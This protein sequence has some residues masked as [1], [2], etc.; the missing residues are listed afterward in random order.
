MAGD[1]LASLVNN[2]RTERGLHVVLASTSARALGA[3]LPEDATVVAWDGAPLAQ[4]QPQ[5][6][7]KVRA[8]ART[9]AAAEPPTIPAPEIA[10][11]LPR[12][13]VREERRS[14]PA[15][16]LAVL[17]ATGLALFLAWSLYPSGS[18]WSPESEPVATRA[19]SPAPEREAEPPRTE[20]PSAEPPREAAA[21]VDPAGEATAASHAD[22]LPS[23]PAPTAAPEAT[24][25][26]APAPP[27]P[28]PR[29]EPTADAE[30]AEAPSETAA[31]PQPP[32]PPTPEPD[33]APPPEPVAPPPSEPAAAPPAEPRPVEPEVARART[34][35]EPRPQAP[36]PPPLARGRL[37]VDSEVP[38][39]IEIDGRP[40]GRTPLDGVRLP[41]GQHRVVARYPDGASALKSVTL[42]DEDVAIF[43]R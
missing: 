17:L 38:V 26:P 39:R 35:A 9:E 19:P 25:A 28:A 42:G 40:H 21:V 8:P 22:P 4:P 27:E 16:G 36:A 3:A 33:T 2:A 11:D 14:V 13:A 41:R 10:P 29:A 24:A 43:F 18:G 32:A 1:S 5:P 15:R 7:P 37:R 6:Q 23:E 30:V 12:R 20:P 34:P 31:A